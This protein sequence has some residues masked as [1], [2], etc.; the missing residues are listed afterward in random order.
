MRHEHLFHAS[1]RRALRSP[2]S[3]WRLR[4]GSQAALI[5]TLETPAATVRRNLVPDSA[6]WRRAADDLE[7]RLR[8]GT[9]YDMELR[10][11]LTSAF[12]EGDRSFW[13]PLMSNL[14]QIEPIAV[15]LNALR[16]TL[17]TVVTMPLCSKAPGAGSEAAPVP[18]LSF[19]DWQRMQSRATRREDT[20]R[21]GISF[22]VTLAACGG[23]VWWITRLPPPVMA[24]PEPPPAAIAIDLAPEPT[25]TLTSP[26]DLPPGP[27]RTQ[28][29]PDPAA[30][31]PP[32][33]TAPSS[34]APHPPI[35]VPRSEESRKPVKKHSPAK[36]LKKPIPAPTPPAEATTAP[37]SSNAS[38]APTQAAPASGVSSSNASHDPVSWQSAVLARLEKF[39]RYPSEAMTDHQE[40]AP[41]VSFSMDRKGH[42]L[43]VTLVSSSGH[44]LLDEEA[45]ALSKRAQPLP[46]PPDSI[47][48]DPITLTVPVE[49]Y[50]HAAGD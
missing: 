24:L 8:S 18:S 27:Q 12:D 39:K 22:L 41:V 48:G 37:P 17:R 40:G 36:T 14:Q 2:V 30:L 46:I 4:N 20:F 3:R 44:P 42:V 47:K 5:T 26:S 21:W 32:K 33:I 9:I 15:T 23:A 29:I 49:F 28:S 43:S 38:P 25:A 34:P 35:P 10:S 50:I 31:E 11:N 19:A 13:R 16:I 1:S 7:I 6:I 45:V